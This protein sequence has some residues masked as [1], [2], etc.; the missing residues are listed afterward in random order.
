MTHR[1]VSRY[2]KLWFLVPGLAA[3]A[4]ILVLGVLLFMPVLKSHVHPHTSTAVPRAANAT[5]AADTM[6]AD[7]DM[8]GVD[9]G[10]AI[11]LS[12]AHFWPN[13]SALATI[14]TPREPDA[15]GKHEDTSFLLIPADAA[16]SPA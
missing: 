4:V 9:Y 2:Y 11:E 15:S 3:M 16:P 12:P 14:S 7:L 6:L 8:A 13:S 1:R 10:Y 5:S